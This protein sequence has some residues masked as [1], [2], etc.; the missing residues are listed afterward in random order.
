MVIFKWIKGF[1]KHPF[2]IIYSVY[3][4]TL[5]KKQYLA[6]KRLDIC[7]KCEQK[8]NN[9]LVGDYCGI[10]G[11]ILENKIRLDNE[12]CDMKKW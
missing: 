6:N 10:C 11:C 3:L 9:I 8:Q 12:Q 2:K 5:H 4:R 1:V 7:N